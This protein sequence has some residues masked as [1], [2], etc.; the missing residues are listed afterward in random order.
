MARRY[1]LE[2]KAQRQVALDG[3]YQCKN[4][5][6]GYASPVRVWGTGAATKS[7]PSGHVMPDHIPY[8]V[9]VAAKLQ[10]EGLAWDHA[11]KSFASL[12]CP[13]CSG[14]LAQNVQFA[15]R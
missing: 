12:T 9:K 5:A 3:F 7:G 8:A 10:A 1:Y 2:T 11:K 6:C 14:K 13:R 15:N 4:P